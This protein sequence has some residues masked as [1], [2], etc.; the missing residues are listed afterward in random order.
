MVNKKLNSF[1]NTICILPGICFDKKGN[2][3]GY[4]KGYYDKYLKDKNIYKIGLCYKEC[5]VNNIKSD[6]FDIKVNKIIY[7]K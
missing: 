1:K 7:P 2:R 4:G 5:I 3:I 6:R